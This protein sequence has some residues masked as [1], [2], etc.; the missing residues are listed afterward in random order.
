MSRANFGMPEK[1]FCREP[2]WDEMPCDWSRRRRMCSSED[3]K[4]SRLARHRSNR[5]MKCFPEE[6]EVEVG[7][8]HVVLDLAPTPA[9]VRRASHDLTRKDRVFIS[10]SPSLPST[11]I[12]TLICRR[13]TYHKGRLGSIPQ[14]KS[15]AN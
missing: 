6:C 13:R 15:L 9:K 7:S 14:L 10:D 11:T 4:H 12:K 5:L 3:S 8:S 1:L 2:R